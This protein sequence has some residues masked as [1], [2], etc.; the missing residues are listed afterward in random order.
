MAMLFSCCCAQLIMK[1]S[2]LDAQFYIDKKRK[3]RDKLLWTW[4]RV[5]ELNRD[6]GLSEETYKEIQT[7]I[8]SKIAQCDRSIKDHKRLL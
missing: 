3:E 8:S 1:E 4:N 6:V 7:K 2:K 5:E